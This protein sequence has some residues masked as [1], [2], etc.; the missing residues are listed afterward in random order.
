MLLYS[1]GLFLKINIGTA[2][3]VALYISILEATG[4]DGCVGEEVGVKDK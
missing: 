1:E 3:W 2:P 4:E